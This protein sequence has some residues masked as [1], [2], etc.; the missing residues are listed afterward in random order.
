MPRYPTQPD[1]DVPAPA[2]LSADFDRKVLHALAELVAGGSVRTETLQAFDA[3][4]FE[5]I[6][7]G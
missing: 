2:N 3:K 6:I 7:G 5:A 1:A 4:E